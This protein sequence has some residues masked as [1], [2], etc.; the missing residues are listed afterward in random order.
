M[1][2][3]P[4]FPRRSVWKYCYNSSPEANTMKRSGKPMN[5]GNRRHRPLGLTIAIL[6]TMGLYGI[7]PMLPALLLIWVDARGHR[8]VGG[9]II[10][11]LGWVNTAL[12]FITIVACVMAWVGRP[13]WSR[14]LMIVL[15][16]LATAFRLVQTVQALTTPNCAIG[17][18][19]GSL[20]SLERPYALCQGLMLILVPLYIIWYMNRAPARAFYR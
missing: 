4:G 5:V 8:N 13:R 3:T 18:V 6:A 11:T 17:Q 15:V 14:W 2:W 10:N 9:E 20:Q 1:L 16:L 19:C 12:G 7:W